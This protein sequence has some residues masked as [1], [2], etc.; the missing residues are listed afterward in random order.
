[1]MGQQSDQEIYIIAAEAAFEEA[2]PPSNQSQLLQ[3]LGATLLEEFKRAESDR[4]LTEQRWLRDLRQ[5]RGQYDPD[6]EAKIGK[7]RSRAFVRKTRVKIKTID[8]RV[9]DLLFPTGITKNW[10]IKETP[11]PTI[12]PEA[13]AKITQ[14]LL[15]QRQQ[16]LMQQAEQMVQQ[17][18]E[19]GMPQEQATSQAREQVAAQIE[20]LSRTPPPREVIEEAAKAMAKESAKRMSD[21]IAD[22]LV[23]ARYKPIALKT[24]HSGHLYGIGIMKGP[25]VEKRIKTR[26][27]MADGKWTPQSSEYYLPFLDHVPVWRF[28]PDMSATELRACRFVYERHTMT[29]QEMSD[30][31]TRKSFEKWRQHIVDWIQANPKGHAQPRYWDNELRTIGDRNST[32]GDAGGT[33]E[34]L[35]RWGWMNGEDLSAAGVNVP[36]DRIHE[37]FFSNIWMLPNGTIIKVALQALDGTTWPYHIYY[38]DKDESTIFPEGLASIMRDDQEMLNAST[39]I[40]IDNAAITSGPQLEVSPH[41]LSTN[42]NI[43]EITP[44]KIWPRNN[45][46]PGAPAIR[47]INLSSNTGELARMAQM[48]ENNA[49]ETTAIPRYMSGENVTSGAAGTSSGLSMMMGAVNIVTK[50]LVT[51][52]DEGVTISFVTGMYHW[53]MKFNKDDSIKG[54][55]DIEAT[56]SASLVAKEVRARQLNEF[57]QL[58][59][60]P[61]D[62]PWIKRGQ[63]N[64]LR[65]EANELVDCVKTQEEFEAERNSPQAMMQAQLQQQ[66]L[67][68]QMQTMAATLEKTMAESQR[69]MAETKKSLES[70]ALIR[71]QTV[72]TKVSAAYA[73]LQAGGVATSN[74]VIAPAGDEILRSSGWQ[75]ATPEPSMAQLNTPPVQE[76][77]GTHQVLGSGQSFAVEPRGNTDPASPGNADTGAP[78][79]DPPD[80][81]PQPA[82]GMVGLNEGIETQRID[83]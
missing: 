26:F 71:A 74:P 21:V 16:E 60:N 22:Q 8:A 82:T 83:G 28:Y 18:V 44:W 78:S 58:T 30:L 50:D 24:I 69:I 15:Q 76:E 59:A 47:E 77:P 33:Y 79:A 40:M 37:S 55:Y 53:N 23:E 81:A 7:A 34:V 9:A 65:A 1:M 39:R 17:A 80:A 3:S 36:Q 66:T 56:G 27:S 61:L 46:N 32:Q 4:Q 49:D 10:A 11:K 35:E 70:V 14:Q 68:L 43:D 48:F 12:S 75:D 67:M 62:D 51:N 54:D 57:A 42:Q 31:A 6:V 64:K 19:S 73:G 63:L 13:V 25:L 29:R 52:Y 45:T 41:L 2:P 38:F 72:E 5:Y 20:Q